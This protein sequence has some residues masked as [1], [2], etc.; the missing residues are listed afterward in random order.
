[1]CGNPRCR[2]AAPTTDDSGARAGRCVE[3]R[4]GDD[5]FVLVASEELVRDSAAF[6]AIFEPC[7]RFDVVGLRQT[8]EMPSLVKVIVVSR[9]L[10]AH[11][12]EHK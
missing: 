6:G 9:R 10:I 7:E 5:T 12:R 1:V 11:D 3:E 8:I 2:L 4:K